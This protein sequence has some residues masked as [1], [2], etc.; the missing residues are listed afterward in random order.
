[1]LTRS[2]TPSNGASMVTTRLQTSSGR[3]G[4]VLNGIDVAPVQP[5][6]RSS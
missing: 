3:A 5:G 1:M 6:A 4:L 2:L